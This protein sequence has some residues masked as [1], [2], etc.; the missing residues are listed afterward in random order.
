M[1]FI[2]QF[3]KLLMLWDFSESLNW[4]NWKNGFLSCSAGTHA[5]HS[6]TIWPGSGGSWVL[7]TGS[8]VLPTHPLLLL[9]RWGVAQMLT[10][11]WRSSQVYLLYAVSFSSGDGFALLEKSWYRITT[12]DFSRLK[13]I[14]GKGLSDSL[15]SCLQ[16]QPGIQRGKNR[17]EASPMLQ[18]S[19]LHVHG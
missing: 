4:H 11:H 3:L 12:L 10:R 7:M 13:I 5:E 18:C 14:R 16:F 8:L 19:S 6:G 17:H 9:S 1:Y 2:I 15:D